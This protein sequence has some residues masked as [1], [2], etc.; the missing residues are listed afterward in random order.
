MLS[1]VIVFFLY[2]QASKLLPHTTLQIWPCFVCRCSQVLITLRLY[3]RIVH[4]NF[5]FWY[6]SRRIPSF[7]MQLMIVAK[8]HYPW[9][10][11]FLPFITITTLFLRHEHGCISKPTIICKIKDC[12]S[13]SFSFS[14]R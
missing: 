1:L 3:E 6:Y 8:F 11:A 5:C 10:R 14:F 2:S 13:F 7:F 9:K 4:F 12:L